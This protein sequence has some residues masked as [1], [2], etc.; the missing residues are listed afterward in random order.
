MLIY[1]YALIRGKGIDDNKAAA[2]LYQ[3]S[4]RDINN[5]GMAMN[6]LLQSDIELIKA[7][8]KECNGKY[9]PKLSL[10]KDGSL[11]KRSTSFVEPEKFT[12]IFDHIERL[13]KNTG[14]SILN[15]EISISPIDGRESP[16]CKYC[17]YSGVCGIENIAVEK[18]PDLNNEEVFE[19]MKEERNNGI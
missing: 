18:V 17:D 10:N 9:V 3:P 2:I 5:T 4:K 13:M 16:A 8:D 7:M 12:E 19:K 11:S 6:G 1:L 14:I 15:G